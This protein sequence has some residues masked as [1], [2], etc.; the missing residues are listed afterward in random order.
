M[1]ATAALLSLLALSACADL[2]LESLDPSAEG[3]EGAA[4]APPEADG[5]VPL[6]VPRPTAADAA[7]QVAGEEIAAAPEEAL[8]EPGSTADAP[9]ADAPH[10][11]MAL[12][13]E[14][15][16]RTSVVF[17]I[18]R[19][20]DSTPS[21][22][23][24]IRITPEETEAQSG[25]CNPQ[26]LRYYAF[27]PESARNPVY[28]PEEAARGVVARDLPGFMAT[29]VSSEMIVRGIADDLE[30]TRPQNVCT[31]KLFEQTIMAATTGQG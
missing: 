22:E 21:D 4:E 14:R 20:R 31:R 9:A 13:P 30:Q 27:P 28:G 15:G 18:D 17:A 26:Q 7:S 12:Q 23:P 3:A 25:R 8:P 24:A 29:A 10:I 6:P 19:S 2:G 16:G 5:A 11:Y 1:R